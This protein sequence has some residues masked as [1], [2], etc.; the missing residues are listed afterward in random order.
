MK[1]EVRVL[2]LVME[3][4]SMRFYSCEAVTPAES[5]HFIG[6]PNIRVVLAE[7]KMRNKMKWK[8]TFTTDF[9]WTLKTEAIKYV[10][11]NRNLKSDW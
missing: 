4:V 2:L 5:A 9:G 6:K 7:R 1:E 8:Y 10:I 11:Y 3:T